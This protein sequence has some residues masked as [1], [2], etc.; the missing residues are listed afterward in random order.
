MKKV[1]KMHW[2]VMALLCATL[3]AA[4]CAKKPAP[5]PE[6]EAV[7]SETVMATEPVSGV[8]ESGMSEAQ[9]SETAM[10]ETEAAIAVSLT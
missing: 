10:Q 9:V 7:P 4:G 2:I 6:P 8:E 3:L 1:L 5:A